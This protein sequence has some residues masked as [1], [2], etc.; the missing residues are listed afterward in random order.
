MTRYQFV[1]VEDIALNETYKPFIQL[2]KNK[3]KPVTF[4]LDQS[5]FTGIM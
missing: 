4:E 3:P 1:A 2:K 5:K